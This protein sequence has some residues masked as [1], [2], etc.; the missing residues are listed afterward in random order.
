MKTMVITVDQI[1]ILKQ[2]IFH[3]FLW[4]C[5]CARPDLYILALNFSSLFNWLFLTIF[6]G[7]NKT[8]GNS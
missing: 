6:Q 5:L 8:V 1:I 7:S 2:A 4:L 3:D